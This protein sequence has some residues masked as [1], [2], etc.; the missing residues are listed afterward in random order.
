MEGITFRAW[1]DGRYIPLGEILL[2]L[3]SRILRF[4]WTLRLIEIAPHPRSHALE[5]VRPESSIG[6]LE[7]IHLVTPDVQIIEGEVFGSVDGLSPRV[8]IRAVDSTSWDI[9]TDDEEILSEMRRAYSDAVEL[10]R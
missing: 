3:G 9:E 8:V 7:L 6:T 2:V 5:A 1:N 10:D 4:M